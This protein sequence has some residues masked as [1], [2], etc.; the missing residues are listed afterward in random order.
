MREVL[1]TGLGAVSSL[2]GSLDDTWRR[3]LAGGSGAAELEGFDPDTYRLR[4]RMACAADVVF[5][6]EGDSEDREAG[7]FARLAERAATEAVAD[8]GLERGGPAWRPERV[9][10][11]VGSGLGGL[12]GFAAATERVGAGEPISPRLVTRVLP[13]AAAG[14][15]G[16]TL[17]AQGPSRA[18]AGACAASTR[19][20][21][22][23]L[24][25]VRLGR[26]DLVVAGGAE[27]ALTPAALAGFDAMRALS[28]RNDSPRA[29]SR[30]FDA[31]RDGFVIA[32]GAGVLVVEAA[33]HARRRGAT[34]YA[35]L[36]GAAGTADA[37]HPTRPRKD[38]SG[39][40]RAVERALGDADATTEAVDL[41]AAH[42]TGTPAGDA[43]EAAALTEA[44]ETVPRV[45][46]PKGALGHA[47]GAAGAIEAALTARSVADNTVPPTLNHE[48]PGQQCALPVVT[49][50]T[51]TS[52]ELAV[53]NAAGFGGVNAS[54]VFEE[55]PE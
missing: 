15:V 51:D 33:G 4:S 19:A 49:A 40:S 39:L 47:L 17:D 21:A 30:P 35:R 10:V 16:I 46:A 24:D 31:D 28:T 45:T 23:A 53:S 13:N 26:A 7:R 44:F 1:V 22:D 38:A 18:P 6:A 11:A 42:A 20:I 37:T 36:A 52:V 48:T 9:G 54:L 8:A 34:P 2:G 29:A 5:D 3:L 43:H 41:V 25:D 32:E 50:P 12:P 55:V 14:R 27:S